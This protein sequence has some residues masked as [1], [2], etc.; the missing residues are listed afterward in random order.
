[1]RERRNQQIKMYLKIAIAL[2]VL[3]GFIIMMC[4][5]WR[6]DGIQEWAMW[7]KT[8]AVVVGVLVYFYSALFGLGG[9]YFA[10]I[11]RHDNYGEKMNSCIV[12]SM[13][14]LAAIFQLIYWGVLRSNSILCIVAGVVAGII[15]L[16]YARALLSK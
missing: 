9:I 7:R 14:G 16:F 2:L 13:E 1:M 4:Q 15:A 11:L 3:G 5:V 10:I 6:T 8:V 12:V